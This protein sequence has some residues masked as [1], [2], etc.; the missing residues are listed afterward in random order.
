MPNTL[1]EN[2]MFV[3]APKWRLLPGMRS[4]RCLYRPHRLTIMVIAESN[5]GICWRHVGK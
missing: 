2:P 5:S 4:K 1:R 3:V